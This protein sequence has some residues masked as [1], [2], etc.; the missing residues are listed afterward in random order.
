MA[1]SETRPYGMF[2][3]LSTNGACLQ[4][5][6]RLISLFL[7]WLL[8]PIPGLAGHL[9]TMTAAILVHPGSLSLVTFRSDGQGSSCSLST[10]THLALPSRFPSGVQP[11]VTVS[12]TNN[13]AFVWAPGGSVVWEYDARGRR[14]GEMSGPS[15]SA[16]AGG[17]HAKDGK[18]LQAAIPLGKSEAG[19]E[20]V[21]LV[22]RD[23]RAIVMRKEG[24]WTLS[25][26]TRV[27]S[28]SPLPASA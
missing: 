26:E 20:R 5:R 7:R 2:H 22:M 28:G 10:H 17:S 13:H 3:K 1:G 27:R 19:A 18:R 14:V 24:S 23:G 12:P 8:L 11:E 6:T 16:A 25:W 15:S 9:S 4:S 21:M